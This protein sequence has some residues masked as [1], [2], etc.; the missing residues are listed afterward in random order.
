MR[1]TRLPVR[2]RALI[3][4][5][6]LAFSFSTALPKARAQSSVDGK[7]G[8]SAQASAST[9]PAGYQ[10]AIDLALK[11][12]Q[13]GNFPE[14]RSG[15]LRAHALFPNARTYRAL[16]M[17]EYELRSYPSA[18]DYL[19]R[20]LEAKV[21]PL[22][23]TARVETENLIAQAR[24]YVARFTF[25]VQP[26]HAVLT[27]DSGPLTLD[28]NHSLLL[29]V[30]DYVLEA[31]AED[32]ITARRDLHV[33]GERD[34][35]IDLRLAPQTSQ[36]APPAREQIPQARE[37][38]PQPNEPRSEE[39]LRKKW[40]LWTGVGAVVVGAVVTGLVL[41]LRKG[42]EHP[43]TGTTDILLPVPSSGGS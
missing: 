42:S 32:Y 11:E 20:A 35:T 24:G 10:R 19:E 3:V 43:Q 27:L 29:Q 15:F 12:F 1:C 4:G 8:S 14:A 6:L 9:A 39:P 33:V 30:G 18:I 34:Q 26:D 38:M 31:R 2:G 25:R 17:V 41:G 36:P 13:L 7:S 40:W 22:E 21:R 16:G 5:L 28:A 23:S 37:Q